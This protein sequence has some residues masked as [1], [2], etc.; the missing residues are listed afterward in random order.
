[1]LQLV[2]S[3]ARIPGGEKREEAATV[4]DWH[5]E[6]EWFKNCNCDPGC[7]CDFNQRPMGY[8]RHGNDVG[9]S[10]FQPTTVEKAFE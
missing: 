1:V 3:P 2:S 8:V 5:I 10:E 7:P 9:K 4:T 6:G